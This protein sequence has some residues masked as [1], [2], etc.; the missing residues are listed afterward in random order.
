M[1]VL[2]I[3]LCAM[4]EPVTTVFIYNIFSDMLVNV[5]MYPG[6]TDHAPIPTSECVA[7]ITSTARAVVPSLPLVAHAG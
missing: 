7:V 5:V 2:Q 4:F 6:I 1:E 3:N